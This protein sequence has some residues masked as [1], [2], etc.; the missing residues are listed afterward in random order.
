MHNPKNCTNFPWKYIV[1]ELAMYLRQ[2]CLGLS[3]YR[4]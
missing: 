1:Y 4:A 2:K 3:F